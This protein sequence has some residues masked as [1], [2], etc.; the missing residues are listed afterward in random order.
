MTILKLAKRGFLEGG[1]LI[2]WTIVNSLIWLG[3]LDN[4]LFVFYQMIVLGIRK[5]I[6]IYALH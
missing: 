5:V 1:R 2:E 6:R 4:V 3:I